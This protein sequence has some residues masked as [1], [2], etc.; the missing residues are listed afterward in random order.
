M[1][2]FL[3]TPPINVFDGRVEQGLLYIGEDAVLKAADLSD[4]P[5]TV[6]IRPEG[7]LPTEK[8]ALTCTLRGVERMGRD[9]SV[10][11]EN[12]CAA[13]SVIRAIVGSDCR[14]DACAETVSFNLRPHKVFLFDKQ[15]GERVN[16]CLAE[17]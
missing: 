6:G 8:G 10:L 14:V 9:I 7:F 1:A 13:T 11:C 15:T 3:G 5:V 2:Q 4:G 12:A 16:A 17:V